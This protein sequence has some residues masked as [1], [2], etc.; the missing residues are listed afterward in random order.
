M[1]RKLVVMFVLLTLVCGSC[2]KSDV[3]TT[4]ASETSE[5][6]SQSEDVSV[7]ELNPFEGLEVTYEGFEGFG[8]IKIVRYFL[9]NN[10]KSQYTDRFHIEGQS[11]CRCSGRTEPSNHSI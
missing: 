7:K 3:G 9:R 1:K 2:G 5:E 10:H 6:K 11:A 8:K 4:K